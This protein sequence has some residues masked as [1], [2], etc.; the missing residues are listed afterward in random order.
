MF[1]YPFGVGVDQAP[2]TVVPGS[3]RL[4]GRGPKITLGP[5]FVGQ[6]QV[7]A[8]GFLPHAAM[9]HALPVTVGPGSE[10]ATPSH[11]THSSS[12]PCAHYS[13]LHPCT[14]LTYCALRRR[15]DL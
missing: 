15:V 8:P 12:A 1:V 9:P 3:H 5:G 4:P 6:G 14:V 7:E 11:A 13:I 10:S 2:T